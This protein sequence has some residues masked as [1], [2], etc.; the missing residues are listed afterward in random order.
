MMAGMTGFRFVHAADL[1]LDTPFE[2]IAAAAPHVAEALHEASLQA[3]DSLVELCIAED[4]AFLLLAGD[5]YDGAE[6]GVRAQLRFLHGVHRLGESGIQVFVAHG[7]HDPVDEGWA[8]VRSWPENTTIFPATEVTAA[9]AVRNGRRLATVHGISYP[10]RACTENLALRFPVASPPSMDTQGLQIGLLHC[11]ASAASEHAAYSPCSAA[12]LLRCGFD[13]WA[14]GHIHRRQLLS[15]G[16]PW[17]AYPGDL[18]GRSPKPAESEPKGALVVDVADDR[19]RQVRFSACDRLRFVHVHVDV[20]PLADLA[21]LQDALLERAAALQEVAEGRGLLLR[22]RLTGRGPV[23][24]DLRTPDAL[25]D[26]LQALRDR[27]LGATPL[28]W[29]ASLQDAT[30]AE[31]DREAL[32]ARGDFAAELVSLADGVRAD[33]AACEALLGRLPADLRRSLPP[34]AA[35]IEA[36]DVPQ[37]L[38][39]AEAMALDLLEGGD[40]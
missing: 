25:A 32:R 39:R 38:D 20:A 36:G 15:T 14:L 3:W 22:V 29:W 34:E 1:H 4:A 7:N 11:N 19:V 30:G 16:G 6:R 31:L 17:I 37:V 5:I 40:Q 2:G 24:R 18:Q 28:L 10:R 21:G 9:P 26:L 27:S 23:H 35:A 13:Y 33:P 8:A 12:D